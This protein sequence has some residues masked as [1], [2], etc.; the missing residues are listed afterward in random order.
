MSPLETVQSDIFGRILAAPYFADISVYL[1]RPRAAGGMTAIQSEVDKALAGLVERGGKVGVAIVVQM[2][3]GTS[4]NPDVPG[5]R[6]TF[7]F[8]VSVYE[9]PIVNMD[10]A[11]G[12]QKSAEDV[13]CEVLRLLHQ[14]KPNPSQILTAAANAIVPVEAAPGVVAYDCRLDQMTGLVPL[15][16]AAAPVIDATTPTAVALTSATPGAAILYSLA[17]EY[18]AT[19][20][21]APFDGTGLLVRAVASAPGLAASNISEKQL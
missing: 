14:W 3:L 17:G 13:A 12:T 15:V 16:K 6:L 1:F 8:S 4:Q 18:P 19:P 7:N 10:S 21:A 20:Y 11:R 5:P 2:P 9:R